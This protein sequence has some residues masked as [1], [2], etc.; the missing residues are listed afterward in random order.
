MSVPTVGRIVR[1][2]NGGITYAAIVTGVYSG[3]YTSQCVDLTLF[4]RPYDPVY[5]SSVAQ[6]ACVDFNEKKLHGTWHWPES[7]GGAQ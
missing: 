2:V 6:A 7:A 1:Y 5:G 3:E 4:P